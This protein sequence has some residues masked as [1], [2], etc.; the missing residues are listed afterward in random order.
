VAYVA[1][2]EPRRHPVEFAPLKAILRNAAGYRDLNLSDPDRSS[3]DA[4]LWLASQQEH[5]LLFCANDQS[6]DHSI[7]SG[8]TFERLTPAVLEL[9]PTLIE[10]VE[11][12]HAGL[13]ILH[14][15]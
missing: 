5:R 8:A 12:S 13:W 11:H 2:G 3:T 6:C 1:S 14:A 15:L 9:D 10:T 7:G 4:R